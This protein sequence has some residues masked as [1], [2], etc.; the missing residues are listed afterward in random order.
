M[1]ECILIIIDKSDLLERQWTNV[2][3]ENTKGRK[4]I[5]DLRQWL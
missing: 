5:N 3:R 1:Q 2:I 4:W